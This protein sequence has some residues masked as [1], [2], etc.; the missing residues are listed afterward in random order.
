M[1]EQS[2]P[3]LLGEVERGTI[4]E[5]AALVGATR[6]SRHTLVRSEASGLA[7][8]LNV[9]EGDAFDEGEILV[10][11]DD[12]DYRV[13]LQLE[14]ASLLRAQ[15][16][17]EEMKAGTRP[18]R[19]ARLRA[20][21]QEAE[22]NLREAR[23]DLTR[24]ENL[25]KQDVQTEAE[26][27]RAR[28]TAE[29]AEAQLL[30]AKASL[31]EAVSGPRREEILIA[32]A[33]VAVQQARVDAVQHDIAKT[34]VVAPY[35]GVVL[36]LFTDVG[37]YLESGSNV[38]QIAPRTEIEAVLE[39]PDRFIQYLQPGRTFQLTIDAYPG[40]SFDAEVITF[41]PLAD[42]QSR[43]FQLR[44][45]IMV[46]DKLLAS[47]MF[48]RARLPVVSRENAILVPD[49]ALTLKN[50]ER[51]LFVVN[52]DNTVTQHLVTIGLSSGDRVEI[53]DPPLE[54][55]TRIVTTGNEVLYPGAK[56]SPAGEGGPGGPPAADEPGA[57]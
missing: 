26:L 42:R 9:R 12:S 55:G 28:A 3:V 39:V 11:I 51:L 52:D 30:A 38:M 45:R 13:R 19:V 44:S 35:D 47:G 17:L 24:T 16:V 43:N 32:E 5:M 57:H 1:G 31:D 25:F 14:E 34:Q 53:V 50:Q 4:T 41:I 6:F 8:M 56:I 20:V 29:Q 7:Q 37:N 48:V 23:D 18:E 2:V 21:V 27:T 36:E 49:D 15:R 54:P 46:G 10:K 40:Q 33:D 22:A